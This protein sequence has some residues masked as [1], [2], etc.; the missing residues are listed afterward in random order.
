MD[1]EAS[2]LPQIDDD[3]VL[4]LLLSGDA[5]TLDEAEELYLDASMPEILRL[6]E[7]PLS[8]QEL[9]DHPLMVL[10]RSHGSRGWEESVL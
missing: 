2:G 5:G 3:P 9:A 4:R 8:D 10:L 1:F 6:I 7:S